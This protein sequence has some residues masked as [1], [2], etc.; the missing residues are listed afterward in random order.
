MDPVTLVETALAAGAGLGVKDTASSAVKDAYGS[1]KAL[2]KKRFTGRPDTEMMLAK[3]ERSPDTWKLPLATELQ[4]A[5]AARDE[6]LIAAART[7]MTLLDET[8]SR[9]GK[10]A[11]D[12]RDSYG[13]M[14]GDNGIQYNDF[15]S[16][17]D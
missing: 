1:L 14:I 9:A 4:E 15:K 16:P 8:G 3:H 5:G 7:L 12:V 6:E 17:P 2:V 13:V 10:Y 11:V